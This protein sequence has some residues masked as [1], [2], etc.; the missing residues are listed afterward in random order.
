MGRLTIQE[1]AEIIEDFKKNVL[2]QKSIQEKY[3]INE[4]QFNYLMKNQTQIL[5]LRYSTTKKPNTHEEKCLF[6]WILERQQQYLFVDEKMI[7]EKASEL[8]FKLY[9]RTLRCPSRSKKCFSNKYYLTMTARL[10]LGSKKTSILATWNQR[11]SDLMSNRNQQ[12]SRKV[13]NQENQDNRENQGTQM[14]CLA[15]NQLL[16]G[17]YLNI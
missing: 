11:A 17:K 16:Q 9:E 6:D 4:I 5:R 1:K 10:L 15:V 12:K 2:D 3:C 13:E 7:N 14:S 8:H